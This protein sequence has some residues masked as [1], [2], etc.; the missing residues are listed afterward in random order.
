VIVHSFFGIESPRF[1]F[2]IVLHAGTLFS[3]LVYFRKEIAVILTGERKLLLF[4]ALGTVPAVLAALIFADRIE[5]FFESLKAV[6]VML[7][8]TGVWLFFGETAGRLRERRGKLRKSPGWVSAIL[9]GVAQGFA[10]LPGI[11]RS[12]ATI[13]TGMMSGL[14]REEAF[15]FSFLLS[16]PA[17]T[18]AF[19]YKL[20]DFSSPAVWSEMGLYILGGAAAFITGLLTLRILFTAVRRK[21]LYY[22]G[23][24]CILAGLTTFIFSPPPVQTEL[25]TGRDS[26]PR[27]ERRP[28]KESSAAAS[29]RNFKARGH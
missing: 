26:V 21:K 5:S 12:G 16:I 29:P 24:Y 11:S 28:G 4:I 1:L 7:F 10:L 2:D 22:F 13:S 6:S 3:V 17:I 9:I 23:I 18:G 25:E 8:V 20:K 14:K 15:R 19:F 27:L